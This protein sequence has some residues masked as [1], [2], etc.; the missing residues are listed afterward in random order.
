MIK[1]NEGG[2]VRPMLLLLMLTGASVPALA[3]EAPAAPAPAETVADDGTDI[4]VTA[5]K[6]S[7]RLQDVPIAVSALGGDSLDKQRVTQARR[8]RG[9][10]RQPSAHFDGRRQHPDL[11]AARRV[12]VGLQPQP[13]EPGRDLL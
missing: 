5:Q 4:V 6:R 9:Q 1:V 12:D 7:E 10:D 11:R 3:Q 2:A 8:T 13:G